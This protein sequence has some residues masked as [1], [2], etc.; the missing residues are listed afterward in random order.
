MQQQRILTL[1]IITIE[2][3]MAN[4]LKLVEFYG[5]KTINIITKLLERCRRCESNDFP[6]DEQ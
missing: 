2:T 4:E 6:K 5:N 1:S 3:I